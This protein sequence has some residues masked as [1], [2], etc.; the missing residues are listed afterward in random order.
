MDN[1]QA[2]TQINFLDKSILVH[3][4][5]CLKITEGFP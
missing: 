3:L 1:T 4:T 2:E 5:L